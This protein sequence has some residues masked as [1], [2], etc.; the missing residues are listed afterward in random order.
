MA[1]LQ[2]GHT[3]YRCHTKD[4]DTK[5]IREDRIE[6]AMAEAFAPLQ[7]NGEE[8]AYTRQ[9]FDW[10]RS[11]KQERAKEELEN[12]NLQLAQLRERL[13]RLTDAFLD[14]AIDKPL[15]DERRSGLLFEEA[16]VKQRMHDLEIGNDAA[17]TRLEEYLELVQTASNLQKMTLPQ[18]KRTLVKRLTSNL[19]LSP[20]RAVI[21]L[22]NA[23]QLIANRSLVLS[24]SPNRGV[25]RTWN[26]ILKRLAEEFET[27]DVELP[28]AA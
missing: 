14:G 26:S 23:A 27:E 4:C 19:A 15:L 13:T 22:R 5:T 25:P 28:L 12:C 1:E 24:G 3:Y 17:L 8:M 21:T 16:G 2:K 18:E 10:A 20:E 9:W 7:L 6:N 11:H